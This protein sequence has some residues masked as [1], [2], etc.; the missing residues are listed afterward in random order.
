MSLKSHVLVISNIKTTIREIPLKVLRGFLLQVYHLHLNT[1]FREWLKW[2]L[3]LLF[4]LSR[5]KSRVAVASCYMN[6]AFH[7]CIQGN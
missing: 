3:S 4:L 2:L 1:G 7:K 5:M 6:A